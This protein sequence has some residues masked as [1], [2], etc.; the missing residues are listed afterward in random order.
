MLGGPIRWECSLG[1]APTVRPVNASRPSR[2][3]YKKQNLVLVLGR[4]LQSRQQ[5]VLSS[6]RFGVGRSALATTRFISFAPNFLTFLFTP[7]YNS[8][9]PSEERVLDDGDEID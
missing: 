1:H 6:G 2:L 5:S 8:S 9:F 4:K 3:N 7:L